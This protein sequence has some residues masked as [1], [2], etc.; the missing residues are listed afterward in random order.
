[1]YR[2]LLAALALGAALVV[3]IGASAARD[4]GI[5]MD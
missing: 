5:M 4:L 3:P 2:L 1:M